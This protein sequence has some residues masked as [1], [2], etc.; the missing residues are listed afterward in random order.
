MAVLI[1][2]TRI[3]MADLIGLTR[4]CM[5]DLI[6]L[7]RICMAVLIGLTRICM[8]VLIGLTRICMAVLIGFTR[9]CMAVLIGLIRICMAVLI[10]FTRIC[11]AVPVWSGS[12]HLHYSYVGDV[13]VE[14]LE[15]SD[16]FA[17]ASLGQNLVH[18]NAVFQV[19]YRYFCIVFQE[20][21]GHDVCQRIR[22]PWQVGN[23][24]VVPLESQ[25]HSL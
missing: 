25:Q 22:F 10:G 2:L 17:E 8:A 3:C 13:D 1:C 19:V 18:P 9:N 6:G 12:P 14:D 7:T 4:I 24:H 21:A 16:I 11:M 5:A 20:G 23:R 15:D